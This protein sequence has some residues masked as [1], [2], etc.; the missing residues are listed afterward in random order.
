[1]TILR[2]VSKFSLVL[3]LSKAW[4]EKMYYMY[5]H[6]GVYKLPLKP[7]QLNV[8]TGCLYFILR[9]FKQIYFG[10]NYDVL[11]FKKNLYL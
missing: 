7:Y 3:K 9:I 6:L 10:N 2:T 11:F 1:V 5:S 8:L 4:R